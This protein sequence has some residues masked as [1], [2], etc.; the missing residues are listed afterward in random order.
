MEAGCPADADLPGR[1]DLCLL[2][3][4]LRPLPISSSCPSY[5]DTV[6]LASSLTVYRRLWREPRPPAPGPLEGAG[7]GGPETSDPARDGGRPSRGRGRNLG[8]G[9]VWA[10]SDGTKNGRQAGRRDPLAKYSPAALPSPRDAAGPTCCM[11]ATGPALRPQPSQHRG[12]GG[13]PERKGISQRHHFRRR[14]RPAERTGA[15]AAEAPPPALQPSPRGRKWVLLLK[16]DVQR[17]FLGVGNGKGAPGVDFIGPHG[18]GTVGNG[19][20]PEKRPVVPGEQDLEK[21]TIYS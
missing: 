1:G 10:G 11:S 17:V 14:V 18:P 12:P 21:S 16:L 19:E 9:G 3:R 2:L 8:R 20:L 13:V 15:C 4:K 7:R 6:P 5:P